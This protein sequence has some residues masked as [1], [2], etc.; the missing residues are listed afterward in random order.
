MPDFVTNFVTF[1]APLFIFAVSCGA[2]LIATA[3][4]ADI[5]QRKNAIRRNYPV[6]G[7]LRRLFEHY[8]KFFRQYFFAADREEMPFNREERNW[9]YRCA[10][11]ADNT[12]PFGST[13]DL[14]P[15][16]TV[17][18]VNGAFRRPRACW[19]RCSP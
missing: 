2:L 12:V 8:G 6:I 17:L 10:R 5:C 15:Q 1:M 7:R 4:I 14:R 13:H 19:S 11:N 9:V 3:F 18:F 16:G